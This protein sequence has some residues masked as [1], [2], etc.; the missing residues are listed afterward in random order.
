[1]VAPSN[2]GSKTVLDAE[3][4][5]ATNLKKITKYLL[6]DKAKHFGKN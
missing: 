4:E 5:G 2:S 6:N 1:L 3:D